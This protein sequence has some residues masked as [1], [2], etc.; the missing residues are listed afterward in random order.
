MSL[1]LSSLC[2]ESMP[3]HLFVSRSGLP[4]AA[5]KLE[6]GEELTVVFIGGSITRGGGEAGYVASTEAWLREN[7]P[8]AEIR[9]VNAGISGTGSDFGAK[10]YDRDVLIHQPD[11]LLIEFAVNDGQSDSRSH[12]ERMVHK[13]WLQNP[14][15][16]LAFFYTLSRGHLD[17]YRNGELPRAAGFHEQVAIH[18][19][20]P[21]IGLAHAVAAKL[22]AGEIEW[23]AFANDAVHP[24]AGGYGFFNETFREVLPQLFRSGEPG[25]HTLKEPITEGL[26]VYPA[27]IEVVPQEVADFMDSEGRPALQSFSAPTPGVH[28]IDEPVFT[29]VEGKTLWRLHWMPKGRS[30]AMDETTGQNKADWAPHPMQWFAEEAGFTGPEGM[31]LYT[32]GPGGNLL[33]FSGREAA[34]LVF[35]A[36]ETGRY[37]FRFGADRLQVWQYEEQDFALHVLHF[38]W[39]EDAGTSR[40]LYR[41]KRRDIEPFSREGAL[42]LT[43]GEELVF[44]VGTNTPGHIRGGWA[45]FR[46]NIGLMA[47]D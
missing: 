2:A 27:P 8:N 38:P 23:S 47:K 3:S 12:M 30:A 5:A 41:A 44:V 45:N 39:G 17:S 25:P 28:W 37:A 31:A 11:L 20:I 7:W 13:T 33:G 15:T 16:D 36:P 43:A 35:V 1:I 34:V 24:H 40:M 29:T 10:R 32:S 18:Y 46:L 14:E 19:G 6:R 26:V 22:E 21:T 9:V 42:S 4:N